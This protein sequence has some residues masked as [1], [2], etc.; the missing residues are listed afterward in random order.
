MRTRSEN[1]RMLGK[2]RPK[3]DDLVREESQG[4]SS[5]SLAGANYLSSLGRWGVVL[6]LVVLFA[7]FSVLRPD[8]FFTLDNVR[9][10]VI[11][12]ATTLLLAMAVIVPLR[13]GDFDL[14]VASVMVVTGCLVSFLVTHGVQGGLA[15][16]L[17]VLVGPLVGLVNGILVVRCG[18]N[19]FIVTLGMVTIGFGVATAITG[20]T[21]ASTL[22]HDLIK[23]ASYQLWGL[24]SPVWLGWIV[25]LIVWYVF[26][27][28]PVGRYLLFIGGNRSSANL[29]GLRVAVYRQLAFVFSGTLSALTGLL[30]AGTLAAV[31]PSSANSYL[32]PPI[33]AVFLGA[34]AIQ[35]GRF[36]V[37][38]TIV[39]IYLLAVGITGLQLLGAQDWISNVFNGAVLII[40]V[41]VGVLLQG[42]GRRASA[43]SP[44]S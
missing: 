40:A 20:G 43:A 22:P 33:T 32:L 3:G 12:Q 16:L 19:S 30:Y 15:C 44:L 7:L 21:I 42:R 4:K 25:A 14:S 5:P 34:S 37:V 23:F 8:L 13:A 1:S 26:Q 24:P 9:V 2:I 18:I 36:N 39:G 38:G 41:L 31:D 11:G 6:F 10:M 27:Y 35:I 29:A 28:T 17:A